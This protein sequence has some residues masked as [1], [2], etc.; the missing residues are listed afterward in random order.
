MIKCKPE[1]DPKKAVMMVAF[2]AILALAASACSCLMPSY[3]GIFQIFFIL[4][5][6]VG[7]N[8]T[9]RYTMTEMEYTLTAESFEVRKKIGDKVTVQCSLALSEAVLLVDKETYKAN[10]TSEGDISRKYNFNQNVGANSAIFIC[11]FNDKKILVEFEPNSAFYECFH[12]RI[13]ENKK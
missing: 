13:N 9:I 7:I 11:N 1:R 6:S 10:H 5:L 4:I 3:R 12:Q 2:F 8:F